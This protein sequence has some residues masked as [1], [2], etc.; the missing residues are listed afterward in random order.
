MKMS[1]DFEVTEIP[2]S[3]FFSLLW[4]VIIIA[5]LAMSPLLLAGCG[6]GGGATLSSATNNEITPVTKVIHQGASSVFY[7]VD[8]WGDPMSGRDY[9][10]YGTEESAKA[11]STDFLNGRYTHTENGIDWD[12]D[13]EW[14]VTSGLWLNA[15]DT[16][17]I[18]AYNYALKAQERIWDG[19]GWNILGDVTQIALNIDVVADDYTYPTT[20]PVASGTITCGEGAVL[21]NAPV[22]GYSYYGFYRQEADGTRT[23]LPAKIATTESATVIVPDPAPGYTYNKPGDYVVTFGYWT[24]WSTGDYKPREIRVVFQMTADQGTMGYTCRTYGQ[25]IAGL[26][27]VEMP[28]EKIARTQDDKDRLAKKA[29]E[30]FFLNR[31]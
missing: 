17:P 11:L 8:V 19:A 26:E 18:R 21:I 10:L 24:A 9:S 5:M 30:D 3:S 28:I 29:M 1:Q 14:H 25:R 31:R 20:E 13:N 27:F 16:T 6:G 4:K 2:K 7:P 23:Y 22:P 15:S 12:V